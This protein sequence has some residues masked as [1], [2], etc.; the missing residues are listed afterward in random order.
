MV[1]LEQSVPG[2]FTAVVRPFIF[3]WQFHLYDLTT[4]FSRKQCKPS[5]CKT[6]GASVFELFFSILFI[7]TENSQ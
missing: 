2:R 1:A 7:Y 3:Y 5:L 6:P 4:L